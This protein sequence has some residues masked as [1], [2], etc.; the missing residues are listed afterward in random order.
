MAIP[1]GDVIFC[2]ILLT[3]CFDFFSFETYNL[4]ISPTQAE[5]EASEIAAGAARKAEK[6]AAYS[7]LVAKV[8][9]D[10]AARKAKK[11]DK[12]GTTKKIVLG[13]GMTRIVL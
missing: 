4:D 10:K 13:F 12:N 2:S 8:A 11:A 3:K 7:S 5:R 9:A 1:F 6:A